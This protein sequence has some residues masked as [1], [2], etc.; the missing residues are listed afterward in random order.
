MHDEPPS[1][2][3]IPAG[4]AAMHRQSRKIIKIQV[5]IYVK[6]LVACALRRVVTRAR[7]RTAFLFPFGFYFYLCREYE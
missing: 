6:Y 3:Y 2:Y 7:T 5:G 4:G 1:I